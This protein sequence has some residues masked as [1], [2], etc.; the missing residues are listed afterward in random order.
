MRFPLAIKG[1]ALVRILNMMFLG[2]INNYFKAFLSAWSRLG[3]A[4]SHT[5]QK[6]TCDSCINSFAAPRNLF[7][8]IKSDVYNFTVNIFSCSSTPHGTTTVSSSSS[9]V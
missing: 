2:K 9:L 8:D 1:I 3:H 6:L 5:C 4:P 7:T